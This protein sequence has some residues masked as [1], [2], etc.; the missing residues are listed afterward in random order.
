VALAVAR[1]YN[2]FFVKRNLKIIFIFFD[3]VARMRVKAMIVDV[4]R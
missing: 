4:E 3:D 2:D 1:P